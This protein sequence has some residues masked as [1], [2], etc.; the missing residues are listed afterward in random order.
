MRYRIPNHRKACTIG[1]M[2][3]G[4]DWT[5][6]LDPFLR[7]ET[8][9]GHAALNLFLRGLLPI[10]LVGG[11]LLW[12]AWRYGRL[13]CGWLCPHFSVVEFINGLMRRA[14]GKP[15]LWER[16]PLPELQPD[17]SRA[18]PPRYWLITVPAIL[19]FSPSSGPWCCSP[20]CCRRWRSTAICG[21]AS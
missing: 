4:L 19:A 9:V 17:G 5:L 10:L 12:T 13:Y 20:T 16:K 6:G 8:G 1:Q 7:G 2:P 3:F 11:G 21:A 15:T 14:S 18:R